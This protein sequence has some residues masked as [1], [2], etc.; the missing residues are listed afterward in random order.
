MRMPSMR[1]AEASPTPMSRPAQPPSATYEWGV[2]T[3][4]EVRKLT[5]ADS[6]P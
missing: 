3:P 4:G 2:V 5:G 6:G 1:I